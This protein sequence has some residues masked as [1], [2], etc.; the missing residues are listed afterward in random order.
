M[1]MRENEPK[2]APPRQGQTQKPMAN[3]QA[4]GGVN[5]CPQNMQDANPSEEEWGL[6]S[7]YPGIGSTGS[8]RDICGP[9]VLLN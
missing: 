4:T 3:P 5:A 7:A 6:Q 8:D 2:K 9:H 1:G